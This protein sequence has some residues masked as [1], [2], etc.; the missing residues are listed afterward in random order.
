MRVTH[1][2]P[3]HGQEPRQ[4]RASRRRF[5]T[6]AAA[7]GTAAIGFPA[8]ISAQAPVK[9]RVQSAWDAAT[10]GYTAFQK[11][12]ANVKQLSEGKL[13]FQSLPAGAVVGTLEMFDAGK[14]GALAP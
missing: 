14:A 12:C 9:W 6:A 7:G 11:Y 1:A 8:V 10:A 5:I 13:E 3:A 4:N 2:I